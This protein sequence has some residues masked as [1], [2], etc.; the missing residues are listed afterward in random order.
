MCVIS[1]KEALAIGARFYFTGKPCPKGHVCER[2]AGASNARKCVTCVKEKKKK[3]GRDRYLR[4]KEK[5]K[6]RAEEWHKKNHEKARESC[7]R[8]RKNNPEEFLDSC[9]KWRR[10]NK[11]KVA[12]D[13]AKRRGASGSFSAEDISD[14][15]RNQHGRCAM[16]NCRKKLND[17]FQIDHITPIKRGGS[18]RRN[19]LQLLCPTCNRKKGA[20][21]PLEYARSLDLLL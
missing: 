5:W 21:D 14:L 19:N 7:A 15:M 11:E 18:N 2:Y 4:N 17:D 12:S 8:W 3:S 6:K 1:R 20:R 16:P 13:K 10:N 9:R